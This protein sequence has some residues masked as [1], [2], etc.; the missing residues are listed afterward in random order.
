MT[1]G[2]SASN[3]LYLASLVAGCFAF[4]L[5]RRRT[6]RAWIWALASV[7]SPLFLVVLVQLGPP[8]STRPYRHWI[9][10]VVAAVAFLALGAIASNL[11]PLHSEALARLE[12]GMA[13]RWLS[14]R[15]LL[16]E[17]PY[18]TVPGGVLHLRGEFPGPVALGFVGLALGTLVATATARWGARLAVLGFLLGGLAQLVM[19]V[20]SV[21]AWVDAPS[22]APPLEAAPAAWACIALV[23]ASVCAAF[24]SLGTGRD[25]LTSGCS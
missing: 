15:T 3:A 23:S 9:Q 6:R 16:V 18:I 12:A 22:S 5:A 25:R 19:A 24:L 4:Y 10:R 2:A 1:I 14:D 21:A 20:Q 17:G 13:A 7:I 11:L 8:C